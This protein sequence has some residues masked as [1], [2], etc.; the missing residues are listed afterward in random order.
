MPRTL[1][2][3][4]LL[5]TATLAQAQTFKLT[6]RITN[7]SREPVAFVSVQVKE[8]QSGT[9]TKEDGTYTL[10]LE[11]GKYDIIYSIVGYKPQV[12]TLAITKDY[13][14]NIILEEDKALLQNVTI[15]AKYKDGAADIIRN[16]I[17]R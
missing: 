11:E 17:S 15:K 7:A 3:I 8:W 10:T 14:Q 16:V 12:V 6:G 2:L 1:L 4:L 9:T 5:S 13:V